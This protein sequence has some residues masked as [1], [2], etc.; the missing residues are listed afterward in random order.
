[1]E[2]TVSFAALHR[3]LCAGGSIDVGRIDV[4]RY[5]AV[6]CDADSVRVVLDRRQGES[7]HELLHR[8]DSALDESFRSGS[9][10]DE[11]G[12]REPFPRPDTAQSIPRSLGQ[13]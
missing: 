11:I 9:V 3:F 8:L 2:S 5:A 12:R 10:I 13:P 1:M 4:W 7:L 6:A